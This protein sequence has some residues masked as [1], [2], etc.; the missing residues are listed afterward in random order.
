MIENETKLRGLDSGSYA[1]GA[2]GALLGALI[3]ALVWGLVY[4]AGYMASLVGL[5]IGFL[6]EKGYTLLKGKRGKGKL[7]IL[8][9]V[10]VLGVLA[11]TGFGFG[12]MIVQELINVEGSMYTY[13]DLP[14]LFIYLIQDPEMALSLLKD[15][16]LGLLFAGLGTFAMLRRTSKESSDADVIDL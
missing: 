6:A 7:A 4:S 10:I 14:F 8:I 3:G 13:A 15:T 16:G 12:I 11:G 1:T 9:A 2:V 5:A